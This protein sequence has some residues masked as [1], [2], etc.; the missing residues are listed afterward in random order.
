MILIY[1][2]NW[3]NDLKIKQAGKHQASPI[4]SYHSSLCLLMKSAIISMHSAEL[5][6]ITLMPFCRNQSI[7]PE[8]LTDSP[9]T[10][11][12]MLN[13][14]IKPLQYQQGASVVTRILSR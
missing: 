12:P 13:W 7:P 14:R 3:L 6:S 2:N 1:S 8:K 11:V 9:T 10:R 5:S 4:S